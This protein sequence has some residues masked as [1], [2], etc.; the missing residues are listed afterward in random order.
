MQ[1]FS[2]LKTSKVATPRS[3]KLFRHCMLCG[4]TKRRALSYQN[5]KIKIS[6][7]KE[8]KS[9]PQPLNLQSDTVPLRHDGI[10]ILISKYLLQN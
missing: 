1:F 8:C 9:H 10:T 6:H 2:S 5:V 3:K 7:F 4:G